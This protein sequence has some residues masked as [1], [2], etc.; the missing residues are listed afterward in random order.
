M[1]DA[2]GVAVSVCVLVLVNV[3][4]I[5][6]VQDGEALCVRVSVGLRVENDDCV[7]EGVADGLKDGDALN[8]PLIVLVTVPLVVVVNVFDSDAIGGL[9][10]VLLWE[11]DGVALCVIVMVEEVDCVNVIDVVPDAV[12]DPVPESVLEAVS[13]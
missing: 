5:V 8:V 11:A 4:L 1:S 2:V 6:G 3:P 9:E 7:N 12:P 13:D 10:S